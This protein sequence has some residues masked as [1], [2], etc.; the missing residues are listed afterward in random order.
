MH[1]LGDEAAEGVDALGP[2][3]VHP[4]VRG[5]HAGVGGGL[6]DVEDPAGGLDAHVV[7]LEHHLALHHAAYGVLA[8]VG[9]PTGVALGVRGVGGDLGARGQV[10]L[11]LGGGGADGVVGLRAGALLGLPEGAGRQELADVDGRSEAARVEADPAQRVVELVAQEHAAHTEVVQLV[12]ALVDVLLAAL[13]DVEDLLA[14]ERL[15]GLHAQDHGELALLYDR[16]GL[17]AVGDDPEPAL[18][19]AAVLLVDERLE[20]VGQLGLEPDRGHLVAAA[21]L[22][23]VDRADHAVGDEVVDE[24]PLA[25]A[26]GAL[27]PGVVVRL[28][29]HRVV[30]GPVGEGGPADRVVPAVT[31][32]GDV[33]EDRECAVGVVLGAVLERVRDSGR[34]EHLAADQPPAERLVGEQVVVRVDE[35]PYLAGGIG[36]GERLPGD[37]DLGVGGGPGGRVPPLRG[38]RTRAGAEDRGQ[39]E[40]E[41]RDDGDVSA[42]AVRTSGPGHSPRPSVGGSVW[43]T[44]AYR[45]PVEI[46]MTHARCVTRIATGGLRVKSP[47]RLT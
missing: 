11:R 39:Y 4:A 35:T 27:H 41:Q 47:G 38:R 42:S 6:E 36:P 19:G 22:E 3:E 37:V 16:A 32:V 40:E 31:A 45:P 24:D 46:V 29:R 30:G 12:E 5:E 25:A 21:V 18:A 28:M 13:G 10:G 34:R 17:R 15:G 20:V 2:V 44:R 33:V 9:E 23:E 14:A 8:E 1:V 43:S 7:D 26:P